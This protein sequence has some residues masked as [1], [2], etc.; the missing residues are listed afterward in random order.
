MAKLKSNWKQTMSRPT[1]LLLGALTFKIRLYTDEKEDLIKKLKEKLDDEMLGYFTEAYEKNKSS[2]VVFNHVA[3]TNIKFRNYPVYWMLEHGPM[4]LLQKL[5]SDSNQICQVSKQEIN[6][7]CE[8]MGV[9]H[10]DVL[11]NRPY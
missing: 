3:T 5:D 6:R 4:V 11:A 10:L 9:E 2:E 7:F 1:F 8:I